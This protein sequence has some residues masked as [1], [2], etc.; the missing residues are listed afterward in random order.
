[1]FGIQKQLKNSKTFVFSTKLTDVSNIIK[2]RGTIDALEKISN[3]VRHWSGGTD[4][5]NALS[6]LNR[7]ILKEGK[8]G[9]TTLILISDGYDSNQHQGDKDQHQDADRGHP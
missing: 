6:S 8:A 5:S 9:T 3:S 2:T 1:M 7:G 4:I